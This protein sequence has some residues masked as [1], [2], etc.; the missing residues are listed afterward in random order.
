MMRYQAVCG[1]GWKRE[2]R[3]EFMAELAYQ[4]EREYPDHKTAVGPVMRPG[5]S[6][7][8]GCEKKG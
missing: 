5:G 6:M 2:G 3:F 7:P 8:N 4:H 1:C